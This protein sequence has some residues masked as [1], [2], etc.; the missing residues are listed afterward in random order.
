M[1]GGLS[2]W[3]IGGELCFG[4]WRGFFGRRGMGLE[5]D[6]LNLFIGL[7]PKNLEM[8]LSDDCVKMS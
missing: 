5:P 7:L 3:E 4:R 6:G 1:F 2:G 8:I